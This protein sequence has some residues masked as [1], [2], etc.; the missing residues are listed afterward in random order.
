V[1]VRLTTGASLE[2]IRG[3]GLLPRPR[4]PESHPATWVRSRAERPLQEVG[5]AL[6]AHDLVLEHVLQGLGATL[7]AGRLDRF[8]Q[9]FDRLFLA[10]QQPAKRLFDVAR[11]AQLG[12]LGGRPRAFPPPARGYS[13]SRLVE[14][15][16]PSSKEEIECPPC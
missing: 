12:D 1:K 15:T 10:A 6:L 13:G 5:L 8:L 7:A 11:V 9:R 3:R 4:R 16:D 2:A 14:L